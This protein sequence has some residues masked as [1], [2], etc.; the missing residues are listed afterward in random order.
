MKVG[1]HNELSRARGDRDRVCDSSFVYAP[2]VH[3]LL[4][5]FTGFAGKN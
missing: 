3:R 4:Q 2:I 1:F 5:A